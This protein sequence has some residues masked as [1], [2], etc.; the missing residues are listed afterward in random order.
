MGD[1]VPSSAAVAPL[2][3]ALGDAVELL[4]RAGKAHVPRSATVIPGPSLLQQC[5]DLCAAAERRA[6]PPV[7]L[8][9]QFPQVDAGWLLEALG[10]MP[11]VKLVAG[12]DP[13]SAFGGAVE[14]HDLIGA[15]LC[16]SRPIGVPLAREMF[17][18]SLRVLHRECGSHGEHLVLHASADWSTG[19]RWPVPAPASEWIECAMPAGCALRSALLV[20]HPLPCLVAWAAARQRGGLAAEFSAL[21]S[22]LLDLVSSCRGAMLL[23]VEDLRSDPLLQLRQ[24]AEHL[25]LSLPTGLEDLLDLP[26]APEG[27]DEASS[28]LLVYAGIESADLASRLQRESG[29]LA[30]CAEL[31][32]APLPEGLLVEPAPS[33]LEPDAIA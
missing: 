23:R 9:L 19:S 32:Y 20:Q 29:Y 4:R 5:L 12:L 8:L 16:S 2:A 13:L 10:M 11:N 1:L 28:A 6:P 24:L 17:G 27:G 25:K 22:L 14:T 7:R 33:W 18:A 26:V 21:L 15:A 31:G 30:L 3:Q